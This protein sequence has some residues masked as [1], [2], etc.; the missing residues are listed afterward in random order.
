MS[1]AG[2]ISATSGPV[3]P[4]VATQFTTDSGIAVVYNNNVDVFGGPGIKT[5]AI[6]TVNP[7]DTIQIKVITDGFNWSEE[8][9]PTYNI[10]VDHGVFCNASMTVNLPT[11]ALV[12]GDSVIIYND[13]GSSVIVQ[14]GAGQ[15]IQFGTDLSSIAGTATSTNVGDILELTYKASDTA[16]HVI[17]CVGSWPIA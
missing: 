1:Q 13:F 8:V 2:D 16:W 10:P 14:A 12:T 6:T 3:P 9:G 5:S 7:N 15:R 11:A 17:A 4:Q